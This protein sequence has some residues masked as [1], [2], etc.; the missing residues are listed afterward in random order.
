MPRARNVKPSF[1]KNEVLIELPF[2]ARLLFIGLWILSDRKG[3]LEDRPKRIKM[4]IFPGDNLDMEALLNLLHRDG[5]IK[6]YVKAPCE[7]HTGTMQFNVSV[8]QV[9][10]FN[11]H[12][13]PHRDEPENLLLAPCEHCAGTMQARPLTE[14]LLLNPESLLP[15]TESLLPVDK[16]PVAQKPQRLPVLENDDFRKKNFDIDLLLSDDDRRMSNVYAPNW[17]KSLLMKKFNDWIKSPAQRIPDKPPQAYLAWLQKTK[18][19]MPPP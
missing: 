1:F 2:E 6:R 15:I 10:T 7:H 11:E 17:D 19:C 16:L 13:H 8:I 12:Q 4:E 5:F 18:K 9:V 3:R 14:S